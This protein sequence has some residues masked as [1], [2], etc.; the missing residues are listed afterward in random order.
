MERPQPHGAVLAARRRRDRCELSILTLDGKQVLQASHAKMDPAE[1]DGVMAAVGKEV[2]EGK[3]ELADLKRRRQ[4]LL[5]AGAKGATTEPPTAKA[6]L[7]VQ[8]E[9]GK[10]GAFSPPR[11]KPSAK[12]KATAR[13]QLRATKQAGDPAEAAAQQAVDK[14]ALAFVEADARDGAG[15]ERRAASA[16]KGLAGVPVSRLGDFF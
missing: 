1:A 15:A 4:E 2:A 13:A 8:E 14:N 5:S 10:V 12:A 9:E 11:K 16:W 7:E 3:L 6:T